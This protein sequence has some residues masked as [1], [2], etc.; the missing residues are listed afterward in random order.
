MMWEIRFCWAELAGRD[1]PGG[2]VS[3]GKRWRNIYVYG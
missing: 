3:G 1:D 2:Y